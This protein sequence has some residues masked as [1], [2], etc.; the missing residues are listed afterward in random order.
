MQLIK[1]QKVLNAIIRMEGKDPE[2]AALSAAQLE[3]RAD[4]INDRL[5]EGYETAYLSP[6]ML[7]EQRQYR[8]TW[9]SEAN[10]AT[11]DE[12][13]YVDSNGD[14]AY[15]VSLLDSN[16]NQNPETETAYW[17]TA[18]S[19][20][21]NSIDLDQ[22]GETVI[23]SLD[24]KSY[25]FDADPRLNPKQKPLDCVVLIGEKILLLG[26]DIPLKP[27]LKFRPLPPEFS[28][29]AWSDSTDYA[30]GDIV[31]LEDY[32]DSYTAIYPNT[33]K[34]PFEEGSYWTRTRFPK[35]LETFVKNAVSSD[36]KT[37]DEAR[38]E[39]A[40]SAERE[41]DRLMDVYVEQAGMPRQAVFMAP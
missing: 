9:D 32:G 13:Y 35:F 33:N 18:G 39:F 20:F 5:K 26:N 15:Y 10:Y 4:L 29:A 27:W 40:L 21:E 30:I 22:N 25:V 17:E 12:V 16:V 3:T 2:T 41:L 19:G 31:Y 23:G 36:L 6:L 38:K 24:V 28:F 14:G 8:A 34:N 11:G 37:E 7:V 1:I